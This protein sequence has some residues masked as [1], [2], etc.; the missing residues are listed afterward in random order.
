MDTHLVNLSKFLSFA[1]RHRPERLGL[2]LDADGWTSL[3]VLLARAEEQGKTITREAVLRVVHENDK[4]RFQL[5]E[6]GQ[7]IRAVQGH[8][9]DQVHLRRPAQRP[10]SVLYHGTADRFLPSICKQGLLPGR[11]HQVHL[12]LTVETAL[13]VGRRHGRP[14]VLK[15]DAA[16]L[17]ARGHRFECAENGVWL[18][19]HVPTWA[20][21]QVS[22]GSVFKGH[23]HG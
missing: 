22:I 21:E 18:T 9:T 5:S 8:S 3:D 1:L 16:G 6:D 11:R 2:S 17:H 13:D 7:Q 20:L 23:R 14:V 12:S 4:K 19:E 15:V 10:P